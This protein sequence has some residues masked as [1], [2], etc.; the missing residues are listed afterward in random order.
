L[1]TPKGLVDIKSDAKASAPQGQ[2]RLALPNN[3]QGVVGADKYH[4]SGVAVLADVV[5]GTGMRALTSLNLSS[6]N[7]K[8]KGGKIVA[9]AIKVTC[10]AVAFVLAPFLCPSD[11]VKL[12]LFTAIHR[13]TGHYCR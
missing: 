8:S 4:L 5:S 6:N 7:L 11:Q 12:L 10:C 1:P 13:I 9:E 3:A 2:G